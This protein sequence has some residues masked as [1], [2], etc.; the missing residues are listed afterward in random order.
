MESKQP[1]IEQARTLFNVQIT[2]AEFLKLPMAARRRILSIQTD[3]LVGES[4]TISA[5]QIKILG[6]ALDAM[7]VAL[8][9]HDH[10]WTKKERAFYD[11]SIGLLE[12]LSK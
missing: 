5:Y 3:K 12:N 6:T 11:L 8:A 10:Q 1:T 7:G 9:D 2:R 4:K